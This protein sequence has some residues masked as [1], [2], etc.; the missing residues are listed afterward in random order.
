MK[1][2]TFIGIDVSK[3]VLDVYI[4]HH[5]FHYQVSNN[6]EGFAKLL[7]LCSKKAGCKPSCLYFAFE[8]TGRYSRLLSVFLDTNNIM[9]TVLNPMDVKQSK[10]LLRGK[11]D[12]K[13]AKMIAMHAWRKKDELAPTKMHAPE[14]GR[15]RQLLSLRDK[16]VRHRT[17]YKN[18]LSDLHDC[19]VEGETDFSR[20]LQKEMINH[21]NEK[22]KRVEDEIDNMI[23]DMPEWHNNYMLIQ[24][25][26]GIGPVTA[27]YILIFTE[28]FTRFVDPKKFACYAGLAPFEYSS[29]NSVKGKEKLHP[30]ANKQ[31]KSLINIAA[32]S[33]ITQKGEYKIY[34]QRRISEGK[35]KMSTLNIVRNKLVSRVF[36]VV[37]RQSPYVD[38]HQFAA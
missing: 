31:L 20:N 3:D 12:K 14:V 13:D 38:I 17:A 33:A 10:G 32:M 26:R 35:N 37:K 1:N 36:A 11:S 23:K 27:K 15:L 22:I 19:F 7:E 5:R 24:T 30:C 4:L 18:G 25:V 29:G 8:H 9:F 16:L 34:Y 21:I 28:N 2:K 6:P